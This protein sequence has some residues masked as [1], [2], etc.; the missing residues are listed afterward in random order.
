LQIRTLG[1]LATGVTVVICGCAGLF[2]FIFGALGVLQVPFETTVN[3]VQGSIPMAP[4][5]AYVLLCLSVVLFAIPV[6]VGF[7]T[8]RTKP[9]PPTF[10]EPIPPPS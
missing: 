6:V 4:T 3:G 10:D 8:F 5:V 9:A 2:A 1:I 7:L